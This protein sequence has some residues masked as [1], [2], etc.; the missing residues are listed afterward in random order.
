MVIAVSIV[1]LVSATLGN[2]TSNTDTFTFT[3]RGDVYKV[4]FHVSQEYFNKSI[5]ERI[6]MV[7]KTPFALHI[8][9]PKPGGG[10]DYDEKMLLFP[11][12]VSAEASLFYNKESGTGG[13][14]YR[15]TGKNALKYAS[16]YR[17]LL[18]DLDME[19]IYKNGLLI[20]PH[21]DLGGEN[22]FDIQLKKV[23]A[24]DLTNKELVKSFLETYIVLPLGRTEGRLGYLSY[25]TDDGLDGN[26]ICSSFTKYVS[27]MGELP[28]DSDYRIM[29]GQQIMEGYNGPSDFLI[30]PSQETAIVI[31]NIDVQKLRSMSKQLQE[32][33]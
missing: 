12:E 8:K 20:L 17:S 13:L 16:A 5:A 26:V 23:T 22:E 6:F 27:L 31:K 18:E 4:V 7:S 14:Y 19:K 28:R 10:N 15:K 33:K 9:M 32:G 11:E 24:M 2:A 25:R 3:D 30:N 21:K 29:T 1:S